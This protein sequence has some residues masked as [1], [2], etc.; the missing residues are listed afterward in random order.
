V[1]R[2]RVHRPDPITIA[3]LVSLTACQ[4]RW[5]GGAAAP[6]VDGGLDRTGTGVAGAAAISPSDAAGADAGGRVGGVDAAAGADAAPTIDAATA[7]GPV[8]CAVVDGV[9]SW[10][11]GAVRVDYDVTAGTASFFR[12]GNQVIGGAYAAVKLASPGMVTS[13]MYGQRTCT[14]DGNQATVVSQGDG[15][16]TLR[17]TFVVGL[18]DGFLVRA[19][20]EGGAL[21]TNWIAPLVVDAAGVVTIGAASDGRVLRVPFDNDNWVTYD[22]APIAAASGTSFEVAAFYDNDSRY[23]LVVGAVT[24]DLW[25]TGVSYAGA[26]G[27]LTSLTVFGGATD[28][29]LTHDVLPHGAVSGARVAS[30]LVF[31]GAGDDWRGLLEAYADANAV[32]QPPRAAPAGGVPFG[33][34]SW[35]KIQ[36]QITY[37]KAVAVSDFIKANLQGAGFGDSDGA[38][39]VNLDS[40]WDNLTDAQL[41]DFVAHCHANGQKAGIYWAPF[42]DWGK[43]ASR[44]VEGTSVTYDQIWLRDGD[45]NP[46]A[47]DGAYAV[48]PTHAATQRRVDT[49]IDRFKELGFSYIKLDFLTHGALESRSH[50]DPAVTTGMA[51]FNRGMQYLRDRIGDTMFVSTAIGPLFPYQ[52]AHARRIACDTYGAAVGT[53][54]AAYE[55]NSVTYGFWMSGRLYAFNDPDEVVFEGFTAADNMTRLLSAVI[56]GTVFLDGDDLTGA[57][58]QALART[59]L[60]NPR[61]NAVARRG[62]T[63]EPVEGNT[64]TA[65]ASVFVLHDGAQHD[66]AVFNF[67][68]A[69]ATTTVDLG[70]AGLDP[71]RDY[72]TQDLW[73]GATQTARGSLAV[74][75]D[76]H[77]A[78]LFSLQ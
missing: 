44:V 42:V 40:Y 43:V 35:G 67:T 75:L 62:L 60:T 52:Y 58:G 14:V 76:A 63:F 9:T 30:P 28:A 18:P 10:G 73:T 61:V 32:E 3:C 33:W 56:S 19:T 12:G 5:I 78:K 36:T 39:Y 11:S 50:A 45:N 17:Q 46:I 55:L 29:T 31:V 41:G 59:Y 25:K 24:H 20:I 64:G 23:G 34:N 69:A 48:D 22:A 47:L 57:A 8:P 66:L 72:Q 37:D 27:K 2:R 77:F 74:P 54:S 13:K 71:T 16:P 7:N 15:L 26:G 38:V 70:R 53:M 21:S 6:G 49:F 68:D 1:A 51:A 4:A 65:P